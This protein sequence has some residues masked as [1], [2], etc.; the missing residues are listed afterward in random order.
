MSETS[1]M[2]EL[3]NSDQGA[4]LAVDTGNEREGCGCGPC[5]PRCLVPLARPSVFSALMA[6]V[7]VVE[8][9]AM[10][11]YIGAITSTLEKEFL[12]SSSEV[13][14]ISIINDLVSLLVVGI[15]TYFG[16]SAHRPR[17]IG[18][19]AVLVGV[20]TATCALPHFI[21]GPF[22]ASL[23]LNASEHQLC[24]ESPNTTQPTHTPIN[25][26][27]YSSL[28]LFIIG[29]IIVGVG[30]APIIPLAMTYVDDAVEKYK[31]TAYVAVIYIGTSVGP[32]MGFLVSSWALSFYV[33]LGS[34]PWEQWPAVPPNDP[35]WIGAWWLGLL[36]LGVAMV[37]LALPLFFFPRTLNAPR[38]TTRKLEVE[39]LSCNGVELR[40]VS[41]AGWSKKGLPVDN[42]Q[43]E[44]KVSETEMSLDHHKIKELTS[45]G[46]VKTIMGQTKDFM[47]ALLRLGRN[48]T[49]VAL[50]LGLSTELAIVSGLSTFG[51][52]FIETQFGVGA[53]RAA[54]LTGV[55]IMP[56]SCAGHLLAGALLRRFRLTAFQCSVF[57]CVTVLVTLC[58]YPALIFLGCETPTVVSDS[59]TM[60]SCSSRQC[61]CD[62]TVIDPVCGVDG[63]T[64][65]S[66]CL[67]GCSRMD[68]E[69]KTFSDC[70]C[71][72]RVGG[73]FDI[74][75][76][77]ISSDDEPEGW[78]AK[79]SAC[80]AVCTMMIAYIV[81]SSM[82]LFF[83]FM[84]Q[85][86]SMIINL[87]CVEKKDRS[88]AIGMLTCVIKV[89]G[90]FPA[91]VFFGV[92][93]KSACLLYSSGE[94]AVE[95]KDT[96][97]SVCWHYDLPVYRRRFVGLMIGLKSCSL[98]FFLIVMISLWRKRKE[99]EQCSEETNE[100]TDERRHSASSEMSSI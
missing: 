40:G 38:K 64:Y 6:L 59:S 75:S 15:F 37:V 18:T 69:N 55:A 66:P 28:Y 70:A 22:S 30:N 17:V 13:G 78:E 7:L 94:G 71:I 2:H 10:N 14:A 81:A 39:G 35:R 31:T 95:Y 76:T 34:I 27:K 92:V 8:L 86:P 29:Q 1:M 42:L 33:G 23:A 51:A 9:A 89:I 24:W 85:N 20:G 4:V 74:G 80:P 79:V 61:V 21:A 63:L 3:G 68:R 25:R 45:K 11:G 98:I 88:F 19:G 52:K 50:T 60:L 62:D 57:L 46:S 83:M 12:L 77:N 82:S 48:L 96:G 49:L 72:Q 32:M 100:E 58:V 41:E 53:G 67:A 93:I 90:F 54:F 91:P 73:N 97:S 43:L 87:R 47:S 16:H 36:V 84:G 65:L 56:A 44:K 5:R 26:S 99:G